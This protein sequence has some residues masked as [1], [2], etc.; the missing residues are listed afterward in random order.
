MKS[1]QPPNRSTFDQPDTGSR[2]TVGLALVLGLHGLHGL[3]LWAVLS[4]T[5]IDVVKQLQLP[6]EV[7]IVDLAPPPA[8]KAPVPPPRPVEPPPQTPPPQ[9][10]APQA[11]PPAPIEPAP[12]A[13]VVSAPPPAPAPVAEPVRPTP[14]PM[15]TPATPAPPARAEISLVCPNH[16]GVLRDA[17]SG[18]YDRIGVTG[19][20]KVTIR[21]RGDRIVEVT[22]VSGPREYWR[23]VQNA[24]KR[25]RCGIEGADEVV[26]PLEVA[27]REG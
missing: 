27:F 26:V 18:W 14:A 24:V 12:T 15:A 13:P 4:G 9:T 19:V 16:V 17:L 21:V 11:P 5:A 23:P 25:L 2:R 20:V 7:A 6:I 8:P 1:L 10:P 22:P 3:L